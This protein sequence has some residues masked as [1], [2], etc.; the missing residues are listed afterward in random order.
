[1][2]VFFAVPNF[3]RKKGRKKGTE[4]TKN[5]RFD[6]RRR[7]LPFFRE[8]HCGRDAEAGETP[9][10]RFLFPEG[11]RERETKKQGKPASVPSWRRQGRRR[12]TAR[13]ARPGKRERAR[14]AAPAAA[15]EGKEKRPP[16]RKNGVDDLHKP[17]QAER[18][19]EDLHYPYNSCI[20]ED[21]GKGQDHGD[22]KDA[23]PRVEDI[24]LHRVDLFAQSL[25]HRVYSGVKIHK[26]NERREDAD[27][28]ARLRGAEKQLAQGIGENGEQA[29]GADG[30]QQR[31][32]QDPTGE[33]P[34]P[35]KLSPRHCL[36]KFGDEKPGEGGEDRQGKEDHRQRHRLNVAVGGECL[37]PRL[38]EILQPSGDKKVFH[39]YKPGFHI[40]G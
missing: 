39:R 16:R 34:D 29:C 22:Q 25:E 31:V 23:D 38:P 28:T 21:A 7:G 40:C 9:P 27:K 36:G 6:R 2:Q 26:G 3:G 30:K 24:Y 17:P 5:V 10:H 19:I 13:A 37:F 14:S 11:K 33:P 12:G 1:M 35:Q 18:E 20:A 4:R 32:M 15:K 8:R